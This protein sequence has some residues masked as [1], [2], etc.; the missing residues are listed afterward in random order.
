MGINIRNGLKNRVILDLFESPEEYLEI[1]G[2]VINHG[3]RSTNDAVPE[4][5]QEVYDVD[6]HEDF[7]NMGSLDDMDYFDDSADQEVIEYLGKIIDLE[8]DEEHDT[9][10]LEFLIE[11]YENSEE[12]AEEY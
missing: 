11:L 7:Y 10:Y 6:C 9:C 1:M 5:D 12:N 8:E 3:H 4:M 2:M